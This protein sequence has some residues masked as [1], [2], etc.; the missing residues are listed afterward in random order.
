MTSTAPS[1]AATSSEP[2]G[3]ALDPAVRAR[4]TDALLAAA[5][6]TGTTGL[7]GVGFA[8]TAADQLLAAGWVPAG[9]GSPT[10]PTAERSP[11]KGP[12]VVDTEDALEALPVGAVLLDADGGVWQRDELG[13]WHERAR[14][15]LDPEA[16]LEFGPLRV[17]HRGDA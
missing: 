7:L 9:T 5:D 8:A 13:E 17:V 11:V 3:G 2:V 15:S 4:L 12:E 16:L 1:A 10:A 6:A 14:A